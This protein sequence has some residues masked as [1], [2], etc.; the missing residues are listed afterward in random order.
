MAVNL[1]VV[2][3]QRRRTPFRRATAVAPIVRRDEVYDH[4]GASYGPP[5]PFDFAYST[6]DEEGTH[7]HS[8]QGDTNGR[9]S[10]EYEL[11]LAD[12]RNR[13]VKYVS[14]TVGNHNE[15]QLI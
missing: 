3:G 6:Q 1:K 15:F 10:G 2:E 11:Q 4:E 12:G 14:L 8:Q 13:L 9:V 7:S 5:E